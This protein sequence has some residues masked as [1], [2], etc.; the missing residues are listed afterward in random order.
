MVLMES[1]DKL[2]IGDEARAF[3]LLGVDGK[4]YSLENFKGRPFLIIFMCN[5]CPYVKAKIDY[6]KELQREYENKVTIIGINSNDAEDYPEDNFENMKKYAEEGNY[7]FVYL[8]DE[9]QD[10]AKAYGA[11]CTPDPFLFNSNMKLVYHGRINDQMEPGDDV[12]EHDMKKAFNLV[13]E[14]KEIDFE[15][16]PS[17]GCSIKWKG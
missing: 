1:R 12:S 16:H 4:N 2:K 8:V 17:I 5:H 10:V 9:T 3:E 15:V 6:I 11:S 13:L 7:N 14:N